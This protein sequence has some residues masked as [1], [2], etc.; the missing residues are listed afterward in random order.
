MHANVDKCAEIRHV[1]NHAFEHHAFAQ[2]FDAVHAIAKGRG[3]EF[4]TRITPRFLQLVENIHDGGQAELF[5]G[6]FARRNTFERFFGTHHILDAFLNARQNA[7]N[8]GI[9][10]W[11]N[12]G[13]VQR[14]DLGV[15]RIGIDAQKACCLFKGLFTQTRHFFQPLAIDERAVRLTVFDDVF[16]QYRVQAGHAREQLRRC[17][18]H[19][20]T[21]RIHTVLNHGIECTRQFA[22]IHVVLI[23]THADGFRINFDQFGQ[24]V[25][26]STRD[27]HR[28]TQGYVQIRKLFGGQ[29]GSGVHRC[30][31]FGHDDFLHAITNDF[32]HVCS[33]FFG[34]AAG[35]A[36]ANRDQP[37]VV[38][39]NQFEQG[40]DRAVPI[41]ARLMRVNRVGRQ[42]FA[43]RVDHRDLHARANARIQTDDGFLPRWCGEQQVAQVFAKNIDRLGFCRFAQ[44]AE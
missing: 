10:F 24:G 12:G 15:I 31:C 37:D 1:G 4:A 18:I 21:H 23:L 41:I 8:H 5:I 13:G 17:G 26:Q 6:E 39:F 34:F 30:A 16:R 33:E 35:C 29:L 25:L 22:L 28:A 42:Q 11:V 14:I 38:L 20:H 3:F 19:V 9:G 32:D 2:I 43:G 27:R 36:V 40:I 44:R 7:F